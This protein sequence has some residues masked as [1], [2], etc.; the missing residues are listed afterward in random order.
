MKFCIA[1]LISLLTCACAPA[2]DAVLTGRV[3]RIVDAETIQVLLSHG[4]VTVRLYRLV[5]LVNRD[6]VSVNEWLVAGGYGWVVG[7]PI[8]T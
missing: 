3:A 7:R 2:R 1:T 6:G 5:A 8:R 4:V